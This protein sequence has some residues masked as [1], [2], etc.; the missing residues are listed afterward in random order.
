LL[1]LLLKIGKS[2]SIRIDPPKSTF[3]K[4]LNRFI[5]GN[6]PSYSVT[7]LNKKFVELYPYG[8]KPLIVAY[9]GIV[10]CVVVPN[11]VIYVRRNRKAYFSGNTPVW[12]NPRK[13]GITKISSDF[14]QFY[15]VGKD[16]TGG[17]TIET[18]WLKMDEFRELELEFREWIRHREMRGMLQ[19]YEEKL[20]H[21]EKE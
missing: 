13:F 1:E 11:Q 8:K 3:V 4:S 12:R 16:G 14:S 7:E 15:Q 5:K 19:D 18:G 6:Y 20:Y 10:W 17:V 9:N 21:K 2:G